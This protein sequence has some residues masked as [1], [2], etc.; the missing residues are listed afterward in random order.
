MK[1]LDE[2]RAYA[3]QEKSRDTCE[4]WEAILAAHDALVAIGSP[5]SRNAMFPS[6]GPTWSELVR[7]NPAASQT[8]I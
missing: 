7:L 3:K 5:G 4:I 6:P 2:A 1:T 8:T